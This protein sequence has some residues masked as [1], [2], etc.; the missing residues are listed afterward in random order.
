MINWQKSLKRFVGVFAVATSI[1]V[2][3]SHPINTHAATVNRLQTMSPNEMKKNQLKVLSTGDDDT[4]VQGS[5][6]I[7]IQRKTITENSEI[8]GWPYNQT[9]G[10]YTKTYEANKNL[11]S[12][13][14][15][16]HMGNGGRVYKVTLPKYNPGNK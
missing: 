16:Q 5:S 6:N 13:N 11:H 12:K 3:N 1:G 14:V 10:I 2:L 9:T 15:A 4:T 8:T 7:K